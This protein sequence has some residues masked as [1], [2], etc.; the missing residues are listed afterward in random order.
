DWE[1]D[2]GREDLLRPR[3]ERAPRDRKHGPSK[4][5]IDFD[6]DLLSV[7]F[8]E[9]F[10][11]FTSFRGGHASSKAHRRD[12]GLG[13]L[14]ICRDRSQRIFAIESVIGEHD[15]DVDGESRHVMRK[16]IQ[17]RAALE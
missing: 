2:I 14:E 8:D 13:S 16:Q 15:V 1:G 9:Q 11:V 12:G 5:E 3:Y 7:S 10:D 6:L 17:S 4:D